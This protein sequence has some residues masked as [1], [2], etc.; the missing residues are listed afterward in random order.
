MGQILE[1]IGAE[2]GKRDLIRL[3]VAV[4]IARFEG[5]KHLGQFLRSGGHVKLQLIK[6]A[7]IDPQAILGRRQVDVGQRAYAPAG[8][9]DSRF[10][11]RV[12]LEQPVQV[13]RVFLDERRQVDQDTGVEHADRFRRAQ[14]G[15]EQHLGKISFPAVKPGLRF[16]PAIGALRLAVLKNEAGQ[17]FH[18]FEKKVLRP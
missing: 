7:L 12:F 3:R 2:E 1:V 11:I 10:D 13:G 8:Q 6:P 9:R 16:L 15:L 17:L 4:G 14:L 5:L 18:P